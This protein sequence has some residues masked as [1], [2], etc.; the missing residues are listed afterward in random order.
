MANDVIEVEGIVTDILWWGK[1]KVLISDMDL[2]VEAYA[3]WKMK[4]YNIK[5][6]PWDL[7]KVELNPYE[8]T[9]WRIVYRSINKISKKKPSNVVV[10]LDDVVGNS[11]WTST[12]S[13]KKE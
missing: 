7:V 6:I 2:E 10:S 4:R 3:A 9:K 13:E 1:Y 8:P 11:T 12:E 5:I